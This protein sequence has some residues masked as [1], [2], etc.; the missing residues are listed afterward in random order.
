MKTIENKETDILPQ[1]IESERALIGQIINTET[2]Y[3]EATKYVTSPEMFYDMKHRRVY[4]IIQKLVKEGKTVGLVE[5]CASF[6]KTDREN[7]QD[8]GAYWLSALIE[9][10]LSSRIVTYARIVAENYQKRQLIK[11]AYEVDKICRDNNTGYNDVVKKLEHIT[12]NLQSLSSAKEFDLRQLITDTQEAVQTPLNLI[13]FGFP[14]INSLS[15]GMTRGEISVIAGRPGHG[16]TTFII[17]LVNKFLKDGKKVLIF[18]REMTNIEMI[19]KMIALRS[20]NLTNNDIRLGTLNDIDKK[21]MQEVLKVIYKQYKDQL[22]MFDDVF[23][24]QD[25]MAIINKFKPDIVID[26][27][28][29]LVR[30]TSK[31]EGRRHEIE[32]I[33]VNYKMISKK[34]KLC[35]ILVSQLNRNIEHR[36]D[37][38]PKMSDLAES[39][40]IE[41]IAENILF[42]YYEYN[43]K[44]KESELGPNKIEIIAAK[45]RFGTTGRM[46]MGFEGDKCKFYETT[47]SMEPTVIEIPKDASISD[48]KDI[49]EDL[50]KEID[51]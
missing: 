19:K 46:I 51:D 27:H 42:V 37:P 24:I 32:D 26:D 11:Q 33:C 9:E 50:L 21:E 34:L 48:T 1:S 22:I 18:N 35:T 12:T 3:E 7:Y 43:H 47:R 4:N 16:K 25:S 14:S 5:V 23:A 36:I 8:M 6:T 41:Q 2:G 44:Y 17:N 49:F 30:S 45:I 10:G 28:I 31:H 38:V 39:G 40:A 13:S 20:P 29:Q 15:G